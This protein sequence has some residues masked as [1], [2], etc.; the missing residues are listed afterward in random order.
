MIVYVWQVARYLHEYY[1]HYPQT[2]PAAWE[3][4]FKE[5]VTRRVC[6][7]TVTKE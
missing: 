7:K 2:Y 5:L 3:Y 6:P 4:G 1:I